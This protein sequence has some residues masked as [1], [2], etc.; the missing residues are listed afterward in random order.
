MKT[1]IAALATTL[2]A[3]GAYA[4]APAS[5]DATPAMTKADAKRDMKVE[6]HIKDLHAKLKITPAEETQ[7]DTVAS[8]MRSN[9]TDMD[10]AIDQRE[11]THSSATAVDDLNAYGAIAQSHADAVKKL[12]EAFAPLYASMTDDQ[13]KVADHVFS[14]RGHEARKSPIAMK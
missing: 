4:Q 13:K 14:H 9:A 8:T 12:S 3:G 1:I 10:A 11:A 6:K 5:T 2:L 7:W